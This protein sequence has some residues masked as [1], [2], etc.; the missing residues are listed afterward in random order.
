MNHSLRRINLH[1]RPSG[2]PSQITDNYQFHFRP[3]SASVPNDAGIDRGSR[4]L[5]QYLQRRILGHDD[6]RGA[7]SVSAFDRN[8]SLSLSNNMNEVQ[9]L[10]EKMSVPAKEGAYRDIVEEWGAVHGQQVV[11]EARSVRISIE[12]YW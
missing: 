4:L 11:V 8:Q 3:S 1:Q 7:V 6:N 5:T 10:W 9:Q 12:Y 2:I